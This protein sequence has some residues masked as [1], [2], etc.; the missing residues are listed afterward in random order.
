MEP[1]RPDRQSQRG[2]DRYWLEPVGD[3]KS[4]KIFCHRRGRHL[5]H[6]VDPEGQQGKMI[7]QARRT[8]RGK[9]GAFLLEVTQERR[10]Y[11]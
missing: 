6:R 5:H 2:S 1:G 3:G 11:T 8:G 10:I 9:V 4:V 7:S